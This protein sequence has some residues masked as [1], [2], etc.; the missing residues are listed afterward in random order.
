MAKAKDKKVNGDKL[1]ST[2]LFNHLF[3]ACNILRG[4]INQ[5]DYK[6]YVTPILFFKRLSDVYDEETAK[7]LDESGGD[8]EYAGFPENHRFVIPEGC[9]WQD[10][11]DR[12]ENIGGGIVYAINKIERANPTTLY[13][14]FSHFDEANWTDKTK[15]SD[16]RLKDLVEHMSKINLGNNSYSADIL[17]DSYEYLIKK[18]ADLSK[19]NAGEFYTPRS[20]VKLLVKILDPKAGETVYDPACGTGG[21]L[22]E[23]INYIHN[24]AMV[25]GRIYG[26]E[27]NF[28]NSAIAKMNLLLHGAIDFNVMQGDTLLEP[29]F[30]T[31]GQM[32]RF[33]NVIANPPFSLDK[34]GDVP[35]STD[36][37]GRNIWGTPPQSNG[38]YAWIQHMVSSMTR[39]K[40][41]CAVVLPQGVLFRGQKEYELRK[42]MIESDKLECVITLAN[43]LFYGATIPACILIFRSRKVEFR[44][45]Q[46]LLID[47]SSIYTAKRAQNI[48]EPENIDEIFSIYA[49]Y[50]SV[51][52]KAKLVTTDDIVAKDYKLSVNQYVEK[53]QIETISLVE[54]RSNFDK[55]MQ[56]VFAAEEEFYSLLKEGGYIDEQ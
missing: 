49:K 55:A 34:W 30:M 35:F 45:N 16:E 13:G 19:K 7:A 18:F 22:I 23:A 12:T 4:P 14:T 17:G 28:A 41:R 32:A 15:L 9:H 51:E 24:D 53:K 1:T 42:Q 37:Y 25:Y 40:G 52:E 8:Y 6:S 21:M 38:D 54:A 47:A 33:D 2:E 39:D 48:L 11:R 20:V 29:K 56:E 46:V 3:E 10:V 5:D 26:Q 43:N 44:K 50:E 27:K 31:R 36:V